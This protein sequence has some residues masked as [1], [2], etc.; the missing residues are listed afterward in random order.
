ML[1]VLDAMEESKHCEYD[2]RNIPMKKAND[3]I[4]ISTESSKT[5]Y[6]RVRQTTI[7]TDILE[8]VNTA[9]SLKEGL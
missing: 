1:L 7:T 4:R 3:N 2:T 8:I 6:N 5:E 9:E